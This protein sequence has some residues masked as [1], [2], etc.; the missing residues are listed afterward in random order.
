MTK[1]LARIPVFSMRS[2]RGKL[3][4]DVPTSERRGGIYDG[5]AGIAL[6]TG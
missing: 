4:N 1:R 3:G 2:C 6:L 5:E